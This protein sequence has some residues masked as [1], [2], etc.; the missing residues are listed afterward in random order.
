[1]PRLIVFYLF[2][3]SMQREDGDEMLCVD[4]DSDVAEQRES[5]KV[6]VKWT[7]EEVSD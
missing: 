4:T 3:G 1:M 2:I 6:K 7:H 5:Y